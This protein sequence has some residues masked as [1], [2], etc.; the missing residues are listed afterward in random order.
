MSDNKTTIIFVINGHDQAE[1]VNV[2][3][4]LAVARKKALHESDNTARPAE[5]WGIYTEDGK[6]LTNPDA[7]IETFHFPNPVRLTLTLKVGAGG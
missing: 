7:K 3:E 1:V 2:H 5:E 6:E 4:S